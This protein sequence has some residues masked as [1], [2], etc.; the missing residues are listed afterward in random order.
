MLRRK[1]HPAIKG[2]HPVLPYEIS[3]PK[4]YRLKEY[5]IQK[6]YLSGG[7]LKIWNGPFQK[8]CSP[9]A[10]RHDSDFSSR[11]I[12]EYP[13][14]GE[15]Q[16]LQALSTARFAYN[17]GNGV[18]P[19]SSLSQKISAVEDCVSAMTSKR[20]EVARLIMW[21]IGKP[22]G[23]SL[24]EFDRTIDYLNDTID[25]LKKDRRKMVRKLN[26][27]QGIIGELRRVPRGV[28]LCMGPYNYPLYETFTAVGPALL[29]G[30]T[31]I[32]KPPRIG[33][34]LFGPLLEMFRDC[35]PAGVVNVLF[36]RGEIIIPPLVASGEID[37]LAFIGTSHIADYLKKL[38][39]R[40]HSM[41]CVLGLEAKNPAVILPDAD[42]ETVCKEGSLGALA[43]NGQRC[44]ALKIFFVH[45]DIVDEFLRK[46]SDTISS[47]KYGMPWERNV[48]VTPL[49]DPGR[50]AYLHTLVDDAVAKGSSIINIDGGCSEGHFFSPA[51]LY[52]VHRSMRIFHEE[53]FGPIIPVVPYEDIKTPLQYIQ[54]SRYGQQAS[55]FGKN[56]R[57]LSQVITAIS[58][59]VSRI[60]INCKCQRTPDSFP[61]SGRKD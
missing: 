22:Y 38:N 54:E 29:T 13:L 20:E 9:V 34:L 49:A 40:Q 57:L 47:L 39:P 25:I 6:E 30:N 12:G 46:F 4:R 3:I 23:D 2:N 5:I 33:A 56:K 28:T 44:A 53:Q 15:D 43:F 16:S 10:L 36:G 35:F 21:E 17:H 8:V 32:C 31:V 50:I 11:V 48:F 59:Q 52:P 60:N 18:W 45:V 37:T 26:P 24:K 7:E 41:K 58:S 14:L 42:L 27:E 1:L 55:I 51:L 61:F 19:S